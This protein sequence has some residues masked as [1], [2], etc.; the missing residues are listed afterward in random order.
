MEDD[1][2]RKDYDVN[3]GNDHTAIEKNQRKLAERK[4]RYNV[5]DFASKQVDLQSN[6]FPNPCAWLDVGLRP[7]VFTRSNEF[8]FRI[9]PIF[10]R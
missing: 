9:K 5:L 4:N 1:K 7:H 8:E 3:F 10:V 6:V 2:I